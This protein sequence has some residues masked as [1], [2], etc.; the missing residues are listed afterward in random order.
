MDFKTDL[1]RDH[2]DIDQLIDQPLT[3]IKM[4]L[5]KSWDKKLK[6]LNKLTDKLRQ[7]ISYVERTK[8]T[9][10]IIAGDMHGYNQ[11]FTKDNQLTMFDFEFCTYGY[12]V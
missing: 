7:Q 9:Y 3:Q 6:I 8:E 10:G 12:R 5:D 4:T 11:H 1:E 2:L